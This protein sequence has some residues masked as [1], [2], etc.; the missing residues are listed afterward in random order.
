M[1]GRSANLLQPAPRLLGPARSAEYADRHAEDAV[2]GGAGRD[3]LV[4]FPERAVDLAPVLGDVGETVPAVAGGPAVVR[5]VRRARG[6]LEARAGLPGAVA[7][8]EVVEDLRPRPGV[9][10]SVPAELLGVEEPAP[11]T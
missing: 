1:A 3:E 11:D 2:A 5:G 10:G 7:A 8:Q 9:V 6:V 4:L